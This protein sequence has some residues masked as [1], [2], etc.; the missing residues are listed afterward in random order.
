MKVIEANEGRNS[1]IVF[2]AFVAGNF[3]VFLRSTL[4]TWPRISS[5]DSCARRILPLKF[6]IPAALKM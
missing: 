3:S 5:T 6:A 4:I 1:V 2:S